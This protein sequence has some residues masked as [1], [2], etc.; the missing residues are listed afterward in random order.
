M[1]STYDKAS[2]VMIPSG[3]K[4]SKIFSQ[5]PVNGDGDFTF[6]RSTAAT[7]VNADGNI[8]KETQNLLLQSND[9][10]IGYWNKI[11]GVV[12]SATRVTDPYGVANNAW[13]L[14]FDGTDN[15][16]IEQNI[17]SL[18]GIKTQSVWL[19]VASGTQA[20]QIGFSGGELKDITITT[21]WTR[22]EHYTASGGGFPRLRC[23]D[24]ATIEV[25]GFQAE[26]GLVARDYIETTTA[27]VEGGIT[28]NVPRLDY[29]D[30]SCPALLL[31]PQRTN[32][33]KQSEY[34]ATGGDN[35]NSWAYV[36]SPV[37][38]FNT[39]EVTSPEGLYNA[40]KITGNGASGLYQT[41][42]ITGTCARS[43]YLRSVS[44]T[45]SVVLK[46]PIQTIT[47]K[48]LNLTTEW[49][50]YELIENNTNGALSG[51]WIDDISSGGI[52][53]WGAQLEQGSYATSYI[54]TYGTSVTRGADGISALDI[55]S[56][57]GTN[58]YTIFLDVET[59]NIGSNSNVAG[60]IFY[61]SVG[62]QTLAIDTRVSV[63]Q[64]D[65]SSTTRIKVDVGDN[66]TRYKG[67]L[68]VTPTTATIFGNGIEGQSGTSR[69][70]S[71][72]SFSFYYNNKLNYN[73]VL[74][75]PEALS[76]ADCITLTT[77]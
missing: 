28:D 5:K 68:R 71:P 9:F 73:K 25:Y 8:E 57:L 70:L 51:I 18:S 44:G 36:N 56:I 11:A 22:F 35:I 23:N 55:S 40:T 33:L 15:G 39:S 4:A 66:I 54:P 29:T 46:D 62:S 67:A 49:T 24:A 45:T 14:V 72:T 37:V 60:D 30:S 48:T 32:S 20:A 65:S 19:R 6:S 50:R 7:R 12:V 21:T 52:Y 43:V 2:L 27:A 26:Y 74:F 47:S 53:M 42:A 76:D 10:S 63:I 61:L 77:L 1:A 58:S 59:E 16:R 3:T 31:E 69:A 13:Q 17:S 75:F 38:T 64:D 34:Y 41:A